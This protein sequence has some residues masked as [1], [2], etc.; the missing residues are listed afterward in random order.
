MLR[1]RFPLCLLFCLIV[2]FCIAACTDDSGDDDDDDDTGPDPEW[3]WE[4]KDDGVLLVSHGDRELFYFVGAD[5][6]RFTPKVKMTFGFFDV[7]KSAETVQPLTFGL[8]GERIIL[9]DNGERAGAV[10]FET[11]G[12]GGLRMRV[13]L[14]EDYA[15]SAVRLNSLLFPNDR[16]W[17]FGEQYSF[18]DFYG[19]RVP[20]WV[21]EQGIGRTDS[22]L[23]FSGEL[24][25]T[26]F[27]MP[28]F[29]DPVAGKGFLVENSEYSAFDLGDSVAGIWSAEVWNSGGMS[30]LMLPGPRPA[31]IVSELTAEIGR[32]QQPPPDWAF[33]GVWLAGQG[34]TAAVRERT[35]TALA[36]GIPLSAVWVQDWVGQ[37]HFGLGNYGIKYRWIH[38]QELYPGL[39]A[40]IRELREKD[41]RFLGYFNNFV[42][43]KYEHWPTALENGYV[44]YKTDG[45]P[46]KFMISVFSGSVLDVS[47]PAANQW[48]QD[49][50]RRAVNMGMSGW[51]ADFGEWLPFD[52]VLHQGRSPDFHNLYPTAWHRLNREVLEQAFPD[53]DFVMF[54]RSGFTGEHAVA[55]IVWAGDQE[56]DWSKTDGLP[57]VI[58]AGLTIGLSGV[59]YFTHDI[60]GFSGG[61][62][63]KELFW[64]WTELGA[65][66]PVMR[67]HDG[68][69]KLENHRF[70]SD[71][72]TLAFFTRFAL[73]HQALFPYLKELV[74][75]AVDEGLPVIRHTVLVDPDWPEAYERTGSGCWA[76]TC[77][78]RRW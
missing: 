10:D 42:V 49:Y 35:N 78:T 24:T 76:T 57:T 36:A 3:S 26:Y 9:S 53:G 73:I 56:A 38:D 69:R 18:I 39:Q 61:P 15:G 25:D 17:G 68:L 46:Y 29:M 50:A 55:Q 41:V 4:L 70:D 19:K 75:Q 74:Q 6:L 23:P 12:Q 16:F 63:D 2:V 8:D 20:I 71:P 62:S 45:K 21:Q 27:P 28:Y 44:V 59:P 66:T 58:T 40:F 5:R 64:R 47:N 34:G 13:V 54:T 37:R 51:M 22:I 32:P 52:A 31:D 65:F 30:C 14:D 72:E 60:A 1:A 33:S 7:E 48:F 43:P 77:C 11:T 67:T